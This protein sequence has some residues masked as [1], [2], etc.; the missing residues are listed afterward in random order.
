MQRKDHSQIKG[1]KESNRKKFS[2]KMNTERK[3]NMTEETVKKTKSSLRM[4]SLPRMNSIK[5]NKG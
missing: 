2:F 4:S 1:R 3:W 5:E